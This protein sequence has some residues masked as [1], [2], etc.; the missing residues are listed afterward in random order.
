[1]RLIAFFYTLQIHRIP[2]SKL[3]HKFHTHTPGAKPDATGVIADS[4]DVVDW[5]PGAVGI[6]VCI[7]G[8]C[9]ATIGT[10]AEVANYMYQEYQRKVPCY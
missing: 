7:E 5:C 3:A 2:T 9:R 4:T 1:M 8:G 6:V 10:L